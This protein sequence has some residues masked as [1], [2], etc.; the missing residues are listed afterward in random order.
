[1]I[2]GKLRDAT[3]V[4]SELGSFRGGRRVDQIWSNVLGPDSESGTFD[5]AVSVIIVIN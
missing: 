3:S 5:D 2:T 1:M 4:N